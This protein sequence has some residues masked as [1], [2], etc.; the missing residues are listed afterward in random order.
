M[1]SIRGRLLALLIGGT[2][3]VVLLSYI[4]LYTLVARSLTREF[5]AGIS[6]RVESLSHMAEWWD[7]DVDD[8]EVYEDG[9]D[10]PKDLVRFEFAELEL[11]E[12]EE[13]DS[14]DYYQVWDES[15]LVYARS[16]SLDGEDLFPAP[17][18]TDTIR[19][20]TLS[21]PDDRP[22]RVAW[23]E[24]IPEAE[25]DEMPDPPD[26]VFRLAFAR[27][28]EGL[29]ET[30]SVLRTALVASGAA[31]LAVAALI[32]WVAVY[33]GLRPLAEIGNEMQAIG[34]TDLAHRIDIASKPAELVP[35]CERLNEM[36]D[37]LNAAFDR[38]R[39][40][41]A[42]VAHELR[43]PLAELRT[44]AEVSG[45]RA[46]LSEADQRSYRDVADIALRMERL[47]STLLELS[48][49]SSGQIMKEI[50]SVSLA[51]LIDAAWK[52]FASAAD[53]QKLDVRFSVDPNLSVNTDSTMLNTI[54]SNL[55]SNACAYT[56][57]GGHIRLECAKHNGVIQLSL[58]NTATGL[59]ATD[60]SKLFQ[61]FWRKDGPGTASDEHLGLGLTLV[62]A[63]ARVLGI[64]IDCSVTSPGEFRIM[65]AL[66]E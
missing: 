9:G 52:P 57:H 39:R 33:R 16:P 54:L 62:A 37:R 11:P 1:N 34:G 55:F 43:T 6:R 47:V 51:P 26:T 53:E 21:L 31:A 23:V 22:G 30:L 13:S 27:S 35:V 5:D 58:A 4:V 17:A 56:P 14:A 20:A 66:P 36:L 64:T 10:D 38:E 40:F 18:R 28:T 32:I 44:L 29:N 48:R 49:C 65:L 61:E 50:R 12:F 59:N 25:D 2:L 60:V 41:N 63:L 15:G 7:G 19:I 42:D 46:G 3:P 24:F 8:E 45:R